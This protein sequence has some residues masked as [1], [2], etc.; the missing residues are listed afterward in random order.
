MTFINKIISAFGQYSGRN[1]FCIEDTFY[2]YGD[3]LS[4]SASIISKIENTC[5]GEQRIGIVVTDCIE[6]YASIIALLLSGRTYIPLH[7][8]HPADR[9]QQIIDQAELKVILAKGTDV[10]FSSVQNIDSTYTPS[11]TGPASYNLSQYP[12]N[13]QQNAYILFTSGSTGIPKG[14]PI[15]YN[16][17]N[18]FVDAFFALGYNINENARFLQMFDL[19]FDLSV[20]SYLIPLCVGGCVYTISFKGMKFTNVYSVLEDHNITFALMVPSILANLRQ[21]F[22][23]IDLPELKYSLFCGEALNADITNE[24]RRCIPNAAIENV[25]GPTE[26]TIFCLTYPVPADDSVSTYN[27]IISIGKEMQGM[28]AI[29]VNSDLQQLPDGEKGELC[30][31]GPQLTSGY[32][33]EQK[34][35]EAF[36]EL[37]GKKYYKTGDIAYRNEQ[38]D[39]MYSGRVDSQVKIQGYR[40]ELSEIEFHLRQ[41]AEPANAVAITINNKNGLAEIHAVIEG[42]TNFTETLLNKLEQ[43]VPAYMIPTEVHYIATFPLNTN[44]KTDRKELAKIFQQS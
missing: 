32:L 44:G 15:T 26:A 18:S 20:M 42:T 2:T 35:R 5:P 41:V 10:Q 34:S 33:D 12:I 8:H 21:Y 6:T 27:G 11:T 39:F 24:W 40:V 22:Q 9:T 36:F 3:L 17:L 23:E 25:Y 28:E 19:T 29:V 43:K 30:L 4:I 16:N 7:P 1:A 13:L 31:Y 37:N 14:V 38:G